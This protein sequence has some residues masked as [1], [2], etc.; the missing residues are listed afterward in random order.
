MADPVA[1]LPP[2]PTFAQHRRWLKTRFAMSR[3][4]LDYGIESKNEVTLE[5][6]I[7][8][9]TI[10]APASYGRTVEP[11]RDLRWMC[12]VLTALAAVACLRGGP[13]PLTIL[14]HLAALVAAVGVL[15][16]TRG[17]REVGFTV[18]PASDVNI[19]VLDER[20][21]DAILADIE[22]RRSAALL[23]SAEP[24][25]D[26]TVRAYLRRLRWLVDTGVL[27]RDDFLR[28]QRAVLPEVS[29]PLLPPEPAAA[30]T[31][32]FSQRRASVHVALD[33][34]ADR[35][36]YRRRTLFGGAEGASVLYR[37]LPEPSAYQ[38]MD[39]QHELTGLVFAWIAI[40][41]WAWMAAVTA[42]Q[43]ADAYVGGPGLRRAL[44]DFGP[45]LLVMAAAAGLVPLL[46][47]LTCARPYPGLLVLRDKHFDALLAA[48]EQRRLAAQRLRAAPDPL[49]HVEEQ[50]DV[51]EELRDT[52]VLSAEEYA[53]AVE[54]AAL[55]GVPAGLDE[56]V[57][58]EASAARAYALH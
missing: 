36:D 35:L 49:L 6:R 55:I 3:R 26:T 29:E 19:L 52:D 33:L 14:L 16:A 24:A 9:D 54:R 20:Q 10:G 44:A 25:A 12:F 21:H 50:M 8:W 7:A 40:G 28:R 23:A 32:H 34:H 4:H 51:L 2:P 38:E 27:G 58:A 15:M 11:D 5:K 42:G 39:R 47:W 43:P 31:L 17:L 56:P 48:I 45:A 41:V 18:V 13:Q 22:A 53:R 37:D 1:P 46:T 30:E 57:M